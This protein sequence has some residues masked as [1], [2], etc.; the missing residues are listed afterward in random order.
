MCVCV[1]SSNRYL[2]N[3]D[4]DRHEILHDQIGLLPLDGTQ[5]CH[6]IQNV[7][8]TYGHQSFKCCLEKM[9]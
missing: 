5:S 1:L 3:V 8:W 2:G 7:D 4:T 9:H 6:K